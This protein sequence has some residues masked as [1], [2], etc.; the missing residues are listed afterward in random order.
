MYAVSGAMKIAEVMCKKK[1]VR[2]VTVFTDSQATLRRL[3]SNEPEPEQALALRTIKWERDL[4]KK[5]IQVEYRWVPAHKGVEGNE[6]AYQ[7][8]IKAAY[9]N[10]GQYTKIQNTIPYLNFV[11]FAHIS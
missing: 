11:S 8:A 6:Q 9:K 10:R 1:D 7:Q 3:Q 4:L 5:T 2:R